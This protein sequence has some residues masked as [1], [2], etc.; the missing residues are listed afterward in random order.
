M[1]CT[2]EP[3]SALSNVSLSMIDSSSSSYRLTIFVLS[4]RVTSLLTK[5]SNSSDKS[6]VEKKG[7]NVDREIK[8]GQG[9]VR[10]Y[11]RGWGNNVDRKIKWGQ[12]WVRVYVRGWGNNVG[13]ERQGRVG[14]G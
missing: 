3:D 8:W 6:D 9:W 2:H 12:G 11:V 4:S 5:S 10:V 13:G 7:N 1:F 14:V